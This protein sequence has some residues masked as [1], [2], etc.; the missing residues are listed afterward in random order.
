MN[1]LINLVFEVFAW[2]GTL[3]QTG[4]EVLSSSQTFVD[5]KQNFSDASSI[6]L[7]LN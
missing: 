4:V 5:V 2:P 3:Q 7:E 6:T 1:T